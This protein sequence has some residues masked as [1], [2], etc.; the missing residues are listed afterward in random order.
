MEEGEELLA[1]HKKLE[2]VRAKIDTELPRSGV[3]V[4]DPDK[5]KRQGEVLEKLWQEEREIIKQIQDI[6]QK[7]TE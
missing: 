3:I 4:Y 5:A 2:E 6:E 1:L 7:R